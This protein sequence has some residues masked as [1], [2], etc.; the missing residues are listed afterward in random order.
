MQVS[1][2]RIRRAVRRTKVWIAGEV[3]EIRLEQATM[4]TQRRQVEPRQELAERQL[5]IVVVDD[6]VDDD[7]ADG[8]AHV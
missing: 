3:D 4:V 6:H 8:K 1:T 5:E 7:L 2:R